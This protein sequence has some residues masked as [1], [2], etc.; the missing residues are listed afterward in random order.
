MRL[1]IWGILE[2]INISKFERVNIA[3]INGKGVVAKFLLKNPIFIFFKCSLGLFFG[4]QV[5]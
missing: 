1:Q 2:E 3:A 5:A 4:P